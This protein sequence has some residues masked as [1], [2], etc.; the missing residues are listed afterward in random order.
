MPE[1]FDALLSK[2]E[3]ELA[4]QI[5]LFTLR[6]GKSVQTLHIGHFRKRQNN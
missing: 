6:E 2:R 5:E 4:G 1:Y 3:I